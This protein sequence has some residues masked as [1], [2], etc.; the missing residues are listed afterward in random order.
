MAA[1]NNR[2]KLDTTMAKNFDQSVRE[3]TGQ[4]EVQQVGEGGGAKT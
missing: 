3:R 2:R 1:I 4:H